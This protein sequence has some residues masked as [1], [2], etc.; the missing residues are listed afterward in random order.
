M[1]KIFLCDLTHTA[2]GINSELIPYAIGCIKSYFHNK[3]ICKDEVN[4]NLY[5]YPERLAEDFSIHRPEIIG[6]SNYMWNLDLGYT[7][8]RAIKDIAPNTLVIFGGPNFPLETQRQV[9]W[10]A[11]HPAVDLYV[12]GEGEE[13][14]RQI[15]E[16]WLQMR[17]IEFIK[18]AGLN[19]VISLFDG[20][21]LNC[22][23]KR[24]DGYDD[25]PRIADLDG[26][27]SPY[28][29]GYLDEFLKDPRLVPLMESNRGCPFTCAFCVDGIG[30]RSKV[31]KAS[32]T[33]LKSELIYIVERYKGKYLT[34]SDTNFGMYKEDVEFCKV[35]AE[36][37]EKYDYPHHLQVSTGKNKQERIINC[38]E[39]LKG[40]LRLSASVQSLDPEV[41]E[42]TKRSNISYQA[43]IN[44]SSKL[45]NTQA[46][47][48]SEVILGLPSDSKEKF[49]NSVCGLI[50]V[51]F[52]QVRMFSLMVL[53]GSELATDGYRQKFRMKT[54]FRVVP[55]SFG[56]YEFMGKRLRSV[57]IEEVN[58][59]QETLP[60]EDYL[61]S[62]R[63]ALTT[64][65]FYNDKVFYELTQ[66]LIGRGGKIS[67]WLKYVHNRVE[68]FPRKLLDIYDAFITETASELASS[69]DA[70][71]NR[72]KSVPG[73]IEE[74]IGGLMGNNV[75][76][77]TQARAYLEAM[78][79]MHEVA[80]NTVRDLVGLGSADDTSLEI[81]YLNELKRYSLAKK[82][83][84]VNL[85]EVNT[86]DFDFDFIELE[87]EKFAS[88]PQRKK[89]TK[90]RF[91]YEQWQ[92]D[93]FSDQMIKHGTSIQGLGK[94]LSRVAIKKT[95]RATA[96]ADDSTLVGDPIMSLPTES[97][98][99]G[100]III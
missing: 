11:A 89:S 53:D 97:Q 82:Q 78:E 55:R 100:P 61:E 36:V 80:F 40:S 32:V 70:L 4:I 17:S 66:F 50:D 59:E 22:T 85:F 41:L 79:E 45:S 76:F 83:H 43:L 14:F 2:Q 24:S 3:S 15:V 99:F 6:F 35:I 63:F 69:R 75:L 13:P 31:H 73:V 81:A 57:E 39:L 34:L 42:N 51:G 26:T 38:A 87:V 68:G 30:A 25:T 33:R 58:V 90:V 92:K 72:I 93:F 62:R 96:Y 77:N 65:L 20:K 8:A 27:P 64:T 67:D 60:L 86:E 44:V 19:G 9:A 16:A 10:L 47:T 52:N 1:I 21:L 91:Y 84:F 7:L 98:L 95:Q 56:I 23:P 5:K 29:M 54:Q 94:L 71:E 48:Y 74:Y 88:M 46:N 18:Q 12:T 37:K 49:I 28:T